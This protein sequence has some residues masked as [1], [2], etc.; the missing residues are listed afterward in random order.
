[1]FLEDPAQVS[2]GQNQPLSP[3]L[4]TL[5]ASTDPWEGGKAVAVT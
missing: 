3:E 2:P 4:A 5:K 1:M